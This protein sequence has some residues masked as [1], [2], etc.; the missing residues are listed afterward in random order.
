MSTEQCGPRGRRSAAPYRSCN[1]LRADRQPDLALRVLRSERGPNST[2]YWPPHD[3]CAVCGVLLFCH[4]N[5]LPDWS[6]NTQSTVHVGQPRCPRPNAAISMAAS[7]RCQPDRLTDAVGLTHCTPHRT[8]APGSCLAYAYGIRR[9]SVTR[10]SSNG[11]PAPASYQVRICSH[12]QTGLCNTAHVVLVSSDPHTSR[13]PPPWAPS[14]KI[15][16]TRAV[17]PN[18]PAWVLCDV[19]RPA[20]EAAQNARPRLLDHRR[21]YARKIVPIT[22]SDRRSGERGSGQ[23]ATG[24][25]S[26]PARIL[27]LI[28]SPTG[29]CSPSCPLTRGDLTRSS[30]ARYVNATGLHAVQSTRTASMF[31]IGRQTPDAPAAWLRPFGTAWQHGGAIKGDVDAVGSHKQ[32]IRPSQRTG[33]LASSPGPK[34]AT[35]PLPATVHPCPSSTNQPRSPLPSC[36]TN[37]LSAAARLAALVPAW[38]HT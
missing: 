34:L 23:I 20:A 31:S 35:G 38:S 19:G 8:P 28:R 6:L 13:A 27:S 32:P 24:T 25:G 14:I 11:C 10:T 26:R 30:T 15:T 9:C 1:V 2:A 33:G 7:L 29:T 4:T 5:S 12:I 21:T 3:S 18:V 36:M 17:I 37:A 16:T 22:G